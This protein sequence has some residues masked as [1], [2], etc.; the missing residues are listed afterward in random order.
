MA[1]R[2][3]SIKIGWPRSGMGGS[4]SG[5][6]TIF[7]KYAGEY[8]FDATLITAQ[9]YQESALDQKK[10]SPVGA[11]GI[12]QVMPATARDPVVNVP[13]IHIADNNLKA[14]VKYLRFLRDH[15][16]NDPAMSE[17]EQTLF[18]FAAYN[19]GPSNIRMAR[20]RAEKMGLDPNVWFGSVEI[21]AAKVISREP[22]IYVRN[23]LKYYVTYRIYHDRV[24]KI[25]PCMENG[26]A[27]IARG[28]ANGH[29]FGSSEFH[30]LRSTG[31]TLPE[32]V[33]HFVRQE[34]FRSEAKSHMTGSVG[35]KRVPPSFLGESIRSISSISLKRS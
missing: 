23:I 10:R 24:A 21:A 20:R 19:A 11:I 8:K 27:A 5:D 22:V 7:E 28:L 9:G 26:K 14:G 29:G 32:Y 33:Y 6:S 12:M 25:T 35:Q 18:A 13:D 2:E 15:Y 4:V 30:V 31:S 3:R 17:F 16:F 1:I 34:V